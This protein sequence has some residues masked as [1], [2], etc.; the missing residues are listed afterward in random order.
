MLSL[1][2]P[3]DVAPV[4]TTPPRHAVPVEASAN[5]PADT[6]GI[7]TPTPSAR[8]PPVKPDKMTIGDDADVAH[9]G[10]TASTNVHIFYYPW[11][12]E[13][14]TDGKWEH[15]NHEYL[16]HW[17]DA[18]NARFPE[19]GSRHA[20]P[21]DIGA[22]FYPLLG[23]TIAQHFAWLLDA[24]V[25]VVVVSWHGTSGADGEGVGSHPRLPLIFDVA[26]ATGMAIALHLE[27]YK[28][29]SAD[30]L[31]ADLAYIAATWGDS[32][33]LFRDPASG[34][35]MHY[36]YDSYLLPAAD[37]A[38]LLTPAGDLSVRKT[39]ADAIF[40]SLYLDRSSEPFVTT[41]GFDGIY[42]YFAS[43]GFT[44]GS[45]SSAWPRLA[46]WAASHSLLFVPSIGPGYDDVQVRP[47]NAANTKARSAGA[48]YSAYFDD[49]NAISPHLAYLS[50][51]SF[52]EWH[53]GT[54]IEP[55][56][57]QR[58]SPDDPSSAYA[59]FTNADGD[60]DPFMYLALTAD[61]VHKWLAALAAY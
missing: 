18:T 7:I 45:R 55:S 10:E 46:A 8:P 59:T 48:Y 33:A 35:P 40:L 16:P 37:W 24:G 21:H 23:P 5:V 53:E 52:N 38:R 27:P 9:G 47:W 32:P 49:A 30:S 17:T 2:T 44:D 25:G 60:D 34:L 50:I 11:Y 29:R 15:W 6:D 19:I 1:H 14:E 3:D 51:T 12:A 42:T 28:G 39:P 26:E 58:R 54:H 61:F 13:P 57:A 43:N 31:A 22:S 4:P 56:V 36:V 20:P 41:A